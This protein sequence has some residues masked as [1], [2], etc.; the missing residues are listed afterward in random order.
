MPSSRRINSRHLPSPPRPRPTDPVLVPMSQAITT[1]TP[2]RR[3]SPHSNVSARS[4][5]S[6]GSLTDNDT[7]FDLNPSRAQTPTSPLTPGEI[8]PNL[9]SCP[10]FSK[11]TES[12][13]SVGSLDEQ[14]LD[15]QTAEKRLYEILSEVAVSI[16]D[17]PSKRK[18]DVLKRQRSHVPRIPGRFES[19]DTDTDIGVEY[20]SSDPATSQSAQ[21]VDEARQILG[22]FVDA[23]TVLSLMPRAHHL[24]TADWQVLANI[25]KEHKKARHDVQHLIQVLRI[26]TQKSQSNSIP[27][28]VPEPAHRPI[29]PRFRKWKNPKH[30]REINNNI[31][32][33][34]KSHH[35][36]AEKPTKKSVKHL[37]PGWIY[38]FESPTEAPN[39]VK[40]GKTLKDP[41]KRKIQWEMCGLPLV[42][43]DDNYRNAFD[44]YSV[45]ESLIKAELHNVRRK[46]KCTHEHHAPKQW[47]EHEE[48]YEIDKQTA[49][50]SVHRWRNWIIRLRPFDDSGLLTPYWHWRVR[51]LPRFID[52]VNWDSWTQPRSLDYIDYQLEEFGKGYYA[53]IKA[54]LCRKDFRFCLTGGMMMSILHTQFGMVGAIW[55]L[56]ALLIL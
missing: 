2:P 34:I 49:L 29:D 53:H 6:A 3:P 16:Y 7:I 22:D 39:H 20:F 45:V 10:Q 38:V 44:H 1:E 42:E 5:S 46:Y 18:I 48:W 12:R 52:G 51:K 19:Q 28:M 14:L 11:I 9:S 55:G 15:H 50:K 21:Q 8:S 4:A 35:E 26:R 31:Y 30:P 37:T 25:Y 47:V 41:Q 40:I 13:S 24:R 43:V 32:N 23:P 36:A 27:R 33:C 54:H 17:T 56:L